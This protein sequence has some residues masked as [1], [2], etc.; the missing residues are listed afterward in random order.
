MGIRTLSAKMSLFYIFFCIV[1]C[2]PCICH[3]DCKENTGN[4][5]PCEH[6]AECCRSKYETDKDRGCNSRDTREYHLRECCLCAYI[7]TLF[8]I[9]VYTCPAF[10][11]SR[12]LSELSPD[13]INHFECCL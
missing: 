5:C 9:W 13:F 4:C 12:N 2:T 7:N 3:H 1:P 11:E 6:P 10:K 8:N